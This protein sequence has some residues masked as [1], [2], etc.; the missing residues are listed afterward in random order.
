MKIVPFKWFVDGRNPSPHGLNGCVYDL[1]NVFPQCTSKHSRTIVLV[2]RC[3]ARE[4]REIVYF[5]IKIWFATNV[6][7]EKV[8]PYFLL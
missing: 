5:A 6:R 7:R 2:C 8:L 4:R 1:R 3:L